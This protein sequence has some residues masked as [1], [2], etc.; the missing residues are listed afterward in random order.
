MGR[1]TQ[2]NSRLERHY[3]RRHPRYSVACCKRQ[4]PVDG[5][6][7]HSPSRLARCE[8]GLYAVAPRASSEPSADVP[9]ASGP[10]KQRCGTPLAISAACASSRALSA[11]RAF[12]TS[13]SRCL[14]RRPPTGARHPQARADHYGSAWSHIPRHLACAGDEETRLDVK[15]TEHLKRPHAVM[16]PVAPEMP[17]TIRGRWRVRPLMR[18]SMT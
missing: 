6:C 2:S 11:C 14:L 9:S 18:S 3:G 5:L 7:R 15:F 8:G 12:E 1:P 13:R 16:M 10:R 17:T 4:E